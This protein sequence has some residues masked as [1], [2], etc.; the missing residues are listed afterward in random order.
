MPKVLRRSGTV[1]TAVAMSAIVMVSGAVVVAGATVDRKPHKK[2]TSPVICR[3]DGRRT[4]KKHGTEYFVRNDVFSPERECVRVIKHD[5]GFRVIESNAHSHVGDNEA[6]PETVYGCAW[7]VCT[8]H[9]VLPR[10]VNRIRNLVTS[11]S[12]DW[13]RVTGHFNVGYDMWFGYRHTIHGHA[14]NAELMIWLGQ[15]GFGT[16]TGDP[17]YTI[18]GHRYYYARHLACDEPYGCWRYVLFRR[19]VPTTKVQ[20][21]G[22]LPFIRIAE[23]R[24]QIGPRSWLKSIDSGF[25]IWWG[26]KGLTTHSFRVHVRLKSPKHKKHRK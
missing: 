9:T 10:K 18:E 16:P 3:P 13:R 12:T 7:G 5:V 24:H 22:L 20:H 23:K 2:A 6:F 8:P 19:V 14:L 17:I 11:W 21:L 25:E 15:K 26:G 1:W 4:I